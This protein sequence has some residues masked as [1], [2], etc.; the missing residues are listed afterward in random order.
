MTSSWSEAGFYFSD[1]HPQF[2]HKLKI[3][4]NL[5]IMGK[6]LGYIKVMPF[7]P[8]KIRTPQENIVNFRHGFK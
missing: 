6:T 3:L 2:L 4:K 1:L 8:G 7:E 5:D